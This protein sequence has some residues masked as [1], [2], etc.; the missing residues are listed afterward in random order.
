[1][2]LLAANINGMTTHYR[3]SGR[4]DAPPLVLINSLGTD[5]RIWDGVV[6]DLEKAYRVIRY[7]KRGHGL[8]DTPPGPWSIADFA[9]DLEGLLRHLEID[10]LSLCGLSVGGMIAQEFASRQP[11]RIRRLILAD[12][13][14]RIG[15]EAMWNERIQTV[16]TSGLASIADAVLERWFADGYRERE[17]ELWKLWRALLLQTPSEGYAATC[18]A[19]RDANLTDLL[20][21]LAFPILAVCGEQD[22]ATPPDLMQEMV[23]LLPNARLSLVEGAG[24][25]PCI[26]R[27]ATLGGLLRRF[28]EEESA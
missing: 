10:R 1:M 3:V 12:T 8:S 7:D 18:G 21:A 13:A 25:L 15:T 24:H 20:P 6:A 27:P 23:S 17:P 26:E 5:L 2:T 19:I 14:H 28:L 22:R 16:R 4:A 11:E 9:D